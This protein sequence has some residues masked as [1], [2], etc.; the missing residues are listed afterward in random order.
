MCGIAGYFDQ[1]EHRAIPEP[2]LR[3][4]TDV[5]AHRG[6]D[7]SGYYRQP[8]IG[9]GHRRLSIIDIAG[10]VQPMPSEDGKVQLIFNGEIYNFR[11]VRQQL[12]ALGHSFRRDSDT[13]VIVEAWRAWGEA[14][15]EHLRGMF[16]FAIWDE[17]KRTLFLARDRLGVKPL[18]YAELGDGR[19]IFGSELKALLQW[20]G[21]SR[22]IDER[23]IEDY[24][25]Y[26]YVPDD[27]CLLKAVR[28]LPAAHTM[29]FRWGEAR[30]TP[31][32]YWDVAFDNHV[33]GS[34]ADLAEEL[35]GRMREAVALTAG[36]A[37][38]EASG[39]VTLATVRGIAETGVDRIS[40][41]ALTKDIQAI[42]L[43]MR[44]EG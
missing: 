34:A 33:R 27:K 26:G 23:A 31:R 37:E 22:D 32:R 7:G 16:A 42:D 44:F 15:V 3:A 8:G 19:V 13:E 20:P 36:R 35:A 6:P 17:A 29:S 9:L 1:R 38:L 28:K 5:I 4:M 11:A 39:G 12:Q 21:L 43:S 2:V 24:F 10:G 25:A 14:C 30:A 18:Y 41:G 40:V